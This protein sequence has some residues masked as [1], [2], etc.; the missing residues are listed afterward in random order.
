MKEQILERI[1]RIGTTPCAAIKA[2]GLAE[3]DQ[4]KINRYL[5]GDRT[6]LLRLEEKIIILLDYIKKREKI[7]GVEV[8]DE[9]C[10]KEESPYCPHCGRIKQEVK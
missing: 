4:R 9:Q 6:N 5:K 7:F 3:V 8:C 1:K 10:N 2:A